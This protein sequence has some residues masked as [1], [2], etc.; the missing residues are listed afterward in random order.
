MKSI[1]PSLRLTIRCLLLAS[2]M[3]AG[4]GLVGCTTTDDSEDTMV[5]P[6][7]AEKNQRM[8]ESMSQMTR[9]FL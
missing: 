9:S 2:M 1:F 3:M 7:P 8:Q 5:Y 6:T 4:F